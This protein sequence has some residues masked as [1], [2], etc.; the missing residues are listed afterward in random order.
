MLRQE[1]N[2]K[3][4]EKQGGK[5]DIL[6]NSASYGKIILN[7]NKNGWVTVELERNIIPRVWYNI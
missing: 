3:C 1:T 4:W 5:V 6:R 2:G 7:P